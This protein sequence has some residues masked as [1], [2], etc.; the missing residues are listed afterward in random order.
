MSV[1]NGITQKLH[2]ELEK[3]EDNHLTR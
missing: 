3:I 1:V 2:F